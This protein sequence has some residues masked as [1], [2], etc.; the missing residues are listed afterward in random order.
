MLKTLKYATYLSLVILLLSCGGP[1]QKRDN[2]MSKGMINFEKGDYVAARLD[3]KNSLQIDPKFGQGYL[4]LAKTE[5]ELGNY[6]GAYGYLNKSLQYDPDEIETH[7]E[8]G[9]IFLGARELEK[10]EGEADFVL[11]KEKEN[12][13]GIVLFYYKML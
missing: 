1:E 6:K 2:F 4:M 11:E 10:A 7:L 9:E 12:L 13:K 5:I 3:F 8:L